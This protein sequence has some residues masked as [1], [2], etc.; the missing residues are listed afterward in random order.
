MRT[1]RIADAHP[2]GFP[3]TA[4]EDARSQK[5]SSW[6]RDILGATQ[7]GAGEDKRGQTT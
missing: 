2:R 6:E 4:Q 5:P 3:R 1:R 7:M